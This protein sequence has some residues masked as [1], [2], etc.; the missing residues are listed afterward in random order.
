MSEDSLKLSSYYKGRFL[1]ENTV[2]S[3][4]QGLGV[5][6]GLLWTYSSQI[7]AST[8]LPGPGH[9][10]RME[11]WLMQFNDRGVINCNKWNYAQLWQSI[12]MYVIFSALRWRLQ[13]Q[14]SQGPAGECG[15]GRVVSLVTFNVA[16]IFQRLK[17]RQIY[18]QIIDYKEKVHVHS[19]LQCDV[20]AKFL[21]IL[22]CTCRC[23]LYKIH[24]VYTRKM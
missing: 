14:G 24:S 12:C 3:C 23:K 18:N 1:L 5:L 15:T 9:V 21:F 10:K 13:T 8:R 20:L 2:V 6:H 11:L 19:H 17:Q 7:K 16:C 22:V 4:T